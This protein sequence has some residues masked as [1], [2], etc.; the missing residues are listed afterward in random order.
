MAAVTSLGA[1]R[2]GN[3]HA[4]DH[5][6]GARDVTLDRVA[7]GELGLER[8]AE[9]RP[10]RRIAS[11]L[12][13]STVTSAP[14]PSA[15]IAACVPTTPPPRSR[16]LPGA[17]PGTPPSR[18]PLPPCGFLEPERAGLHRHAAR[19]FRH[20]RQQRQSAVRRRDRLVGDAYGAA[21]DQRAGLLGVG[22]EMQIA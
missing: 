20:R 19:D 9:L 13:S 21:R 12:R 16:R 15:I 11:G 2:A 8:R 4:A 3:Q 22:R 7:R 1:A 18:M 14:M 10:Q 6:I 5:E 17:T